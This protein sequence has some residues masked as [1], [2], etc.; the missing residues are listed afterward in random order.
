MS[1]SK[2]A[3]SGNN[4]NIISKVPFNP[5]VIFPEEILKKVFDFSYG[6]TFGKAGE[7]RAYRSGGQY[8]RRNGELFINTFQGKLAEFGIYKYFM[9]NNL[10]EFDAPDLSTWELGKWDLTDIVYKENKINIKSTKY[11]GNL[12]LLET[13][14]WGSNGSY[15]P[16][17]DIDGGNYD[18]Y[19]LTR[20]SPDGEKVMKM[21]RF[22]FS[23][24]IDGGDENLWRA[25]NKDKWGFD[26][27]GYITHDDLIHII[28][29]KYILPQNSML[30][31][32]VPMD[33]ENYYVQAGDMRKPEELITLLSS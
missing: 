16:N 25:I 32:T 20:I 21:N 4:Y 24:S 18:Y 14:D 5:L 29:E 33:A 2:L 9:M 3:S 10:S 7:H 13:K 15:I 23:D 28:N 8:S 1:F 31:G 17:Q 27:A 26:I 22:F 12:L 19:I 30:N 6:M 11:Y